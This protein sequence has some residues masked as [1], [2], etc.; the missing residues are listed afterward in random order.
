MKKIKSDGV[1]HQIIRTDKWNDE[2]II[3]LKVKAEVF[4]M[5]KYS[6]Q[7]IHNYCTDCLHSLTLLK[8]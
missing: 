8:Y 4:H 6:K 5:M 3:G 1:G 7:S 2:I